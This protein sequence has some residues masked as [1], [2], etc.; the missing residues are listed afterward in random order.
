MKGF[1][2]HVRTVQSNVV[3]FLVFAAMIFVSCKNQQGAYYISQTGNDSNPGTKAKPFRTLQKINS[4]KL[5]P[6][7]RIYLKERSFFREHYHLQ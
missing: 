3:F 7:D 4:L 1:M 5:N 6:G 2:D